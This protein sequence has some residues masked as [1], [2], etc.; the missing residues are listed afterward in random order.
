M[1]NSPMFAFADQEMAMRV[2]S[3][4]SRLLVGEEVRW[5]DNLLLIFICTLPVWFILFITIAKT[6]AKVIAEL[7]VEI[8]EALEVFSKNDRMM[9]IRMGEQLEETKRTN[10][11]LSKLV[12]KK[13]PNSPD[14]H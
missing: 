6:S 3:T 4:I 2:I 5:L 1:Y 7:I 13:K 12:V 9:F 8:V 10:E 14:D 11:I